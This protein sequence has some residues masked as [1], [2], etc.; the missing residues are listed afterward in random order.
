MNWSEL[1]AQ[2]KNNPELKALLSRMAGNVEPVLDKAGVQAA[3]EGIEQNIKNVRAE[4]LSKVLPP[5]PIKSADES[6]NIFN[7]GQNFDLV[8]EPRTEQ[9]FRLVGEPHGT[10]YPINPSSV[11]SLA[12]RESTLPVVRNESG[13]PATLQANEPAMRDVTPPAPP[14]E[15]PPSLSLSAAPEGD[16][17]ST[18][19][20]VGLGSIAGGAALLGLQGDTSNPTSEEP[21]RKEASSEVIE[22]K[23]KAIAPSKEKTDEND[24]EDTDESDVTPSQKTQPEAKKPE[25]ETSAPQKEEPAKQVTPSNFLNFDSQSNGQNEL[26]KLLDQQKEEV[27]NQRMAE[28]G[29]RIGGAF[30]GVK[31]DL[32]M[33]NQ[34]IKDAGLPIQQYQLKQQNEEN[35]PNSG[36]SRGMRDYMQKLG[37]PVSPNSSAAHIKSVLP[38]IFKDVEA[39]QTQAAHAADLKN[40]LDVAQKMKETQLEQ[41]KSLLEQRKMDKKEAADQKREDSL[42]KED[43]NR[44]DKFNK[45]ITAEVASSRSAFGQAARNHQSIENAQAL[46]NGSLDPNDLDTRQVYELTKTL[47]RILS[48]AGGSVAGTEH[49]TPDTARSRLSKLMEFISNKRQGAQAGSFVKTFSE[50]LDREQEI[51]KQQMFRTQKALMGNTRDLQKRH[52]QEMQDILTQHGLP[53]DM[54]DKDI[55]ETQK[56]FSIGSDPKDQAAIKTIM[57]NNP[58]ISIQDAAKALNNYKSQN[59]HQ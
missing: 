30:A 23:H 33:Y 55:P 39:K 8:G 45:S 34:A 44:L 40:R 3:T 18:G 56:R 13:V 22:E 15:P 58:G 53:A 4:N 20:K 31:P 32:E 26:N 51:A 6:A 50:T 10:N 11:E 1:L 12:S 17:L 36:L 42:Q 29:A 21:Q 57:K 52:P 38:F 35:D 19:A 9:N 41:N 48:Q 28:A 47:D 46:L 54:F 27:R 59:G 16:G 7:Q 2:A 43:V 5:A 24:E 25:A 49:L 14:S 37:Y